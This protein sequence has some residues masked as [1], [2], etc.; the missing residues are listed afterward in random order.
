MVLLTVKELAVQL[1]ISTKTVY[2]AYRN[3]EIPAAQ[4]RRMLMFDLDKVRRA[5]E[6]R[7]EQ[8]PYQRCTKGR[9]ATGGNRRR[10]ARANSP[11]SVTRGLG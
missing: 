11:R 5:M 10:R 9:R 4:F 2:R 3:R 1:G 8:M 6:E 7:A